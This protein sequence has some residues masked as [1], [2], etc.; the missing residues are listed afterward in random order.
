MALLAE[1]R[2][3]AR[4]LRRAPGFTAVAVA[5]LAIG[6]GAN[7]AIFGMVDAV[8]LRSLP[9]PDQDRLVMA[10]QDFTRRDGP[11]DEWF[12]P[13]NYRDWRDQAS[14]FEALGAFSGA[15]VTLTGDG[16]AEAVAG[17]VVTREFL[18]ALGA[19]PIMGRLFLPEE[20]VAGG[21]DVV[22]LG[23]G[24]W[25]G[26]FGGDP[27]IVGTSLDLN[28]EPYR[29]VGV[30]QPG[31]EF[32]ML[33]GQDIFLPLAMD[34]SS[35][36]RGA[37]FLRVVGKLAPGVSLERARAE[38]SSIAARLEAEHPDYNT[39]V[40]GRI[41]PLRDVLVGD[42]RL[43][44][45]VLFGGVGA[46]LL[47]ACVNL[48]NLLLARG[49]RRRRE[50]AVQAALGAGGLR[51]ARLQLLETGIL[52]V[53][54]AAAGL[55]LALWLMELL[56]AM[57]PLGLP[58]MFQPS[59]D[60]RVV[61]FTALLAAVTAAGFGLVPAI[62]AARPDLAETLK[63]G[64]RAGS[65]RA[66]GRRALVV[67][68]LAFALALLIAAGLLTRSFVGLQ[69]VDPGFRPQGV[70][71]AALTTPQASYPE[72]EQVVSFYDD[73]LER[74]RALPGVDAA[75]GTSNIPFGGGGTD[76]G[77]VIEGQPAPGPGESNILWYRQVTPTYFDAIGL[78]IVSGRAFTSADRDGTDRVVI[79]SQAAANRFFPGEDPV[80]RRIKPGSD[81]AAENPWWTVVGVAG[82]AHHSDL[83]GDPRIEGYIAHAQYPAR[84]TTIV[85]R[86][87]SDDPASL[88]QPVRDVVRGMDANIAL[89]NVS[90]LQ[91]LVSGSV[92]LE[93][94]LTLCIAA[95]AVL[96]L[97]LAAIGVYG[98]ISQLVGQRTRE[99]GIRVALGADRARVLRMVLGQGAVLIALGAALGILGAFVVARLVRG[100][101]FGVAPVDPLTFVLVPVALVAVALVATYVPARRAAAVD[102]V[103]A[104]RTE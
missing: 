44:L 84:S 41:E 83:S 95:F 11:A 25:Q 96:A 92:A 53:T 100:L 103:T 80:G 9:Y 85:V 52:A 99:I 86:T 6:I 23:H 66:T 19:R 30:L 57:S 32:P 81:P 56:V 24:L 8:L 94:F 72:S 46:V 38:V 64:G 10:W 70:L 21:P 71:T 15:S 91:E 12:S 73:L 90:T 39:G 55:L 29:V 77:F 18:S 28:G 79:L 49:A 51:M 74:L 82:S 76:L 37:I 43:G 3:A 7:A 59:L 89:R 45:L 60:A 87:A 1:L 34:P 75:A 2:Y 58:A 4:R 63:E 102:P 48:A 69:S 42:V 14:S 40:G 68:Q 27:A 33:S 16:E 104:L 65:A 98:V 97:L 31:F 20:D 93:R 36:S 5:T 26:R 62:Q 17:G 13:A 101:L 54:G 67:A 61:G 47:I 78:P 50:N 22:L 35:P 88:A